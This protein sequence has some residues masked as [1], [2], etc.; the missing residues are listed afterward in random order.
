MEAGSEMPQCKFI[1]ANGEQCGNNAIEGKDHCRL[2]AHRE[3]KAAIRR[4]KR[5]LKWAGSLLLAICTLC[6]GIT[7]MTS[8]AHVTAGDPSR[9]SPLSAPLAVTNT[10]GIFTLI[11]LNPT[12]YINQFVF[13]N[14]QTTESAI[15]GGYQPRIP[16]LGTGGTDT[17]YCFGDAGVSWPGPFASADVS[18]TVQYDLALDLPGC[19]LR[20]PLIHKE[21][22]QRLRTDPT[23]SGK[24]KWL[25][26]GLRRAPVPKP[27]PKTTPNKPGPY[28]YLQ[29]RSTGMCA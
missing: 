1:K 9:E 27:H 4:V 15:L 24:L 29:P 16:S 5:F 21:S 7:A 13:A 28:D 19:L 18:I 23:S 11:D 26:W 6:G 14:G 2:I 12:C 25:P 22:E 20:L 3:T 10:S 17:I 8:F